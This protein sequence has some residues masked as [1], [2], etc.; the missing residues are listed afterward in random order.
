MGPVV[1]VICGL[2]VG[3]WEGKENIGE[4]AIWWKLILGGAVEI[5][6]MLG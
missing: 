3:Y 1:V 6:A 2:G 4:S 5:E